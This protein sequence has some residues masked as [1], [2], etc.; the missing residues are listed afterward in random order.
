MAEEQ[1]GLSYT[2]RFIPDTT[3][4]DASITEIAK[5]VEDEVGQAIRKARTTA[6][7][8]DGAP[9]GVT[10]IE[11]AGVV[12]RIISEFRSVKERIT[13]MMQKYG[14]LAGEAMALGHPTG[15][16]LGGVMEK[17][18][19]KLAVTRPEDL[20]DDMRL[21]IAGAMS[22]I[23]QRIEAMQELR[24]DLSK[25]EATKMVMQ[26]RIGELKGIDTKGVFKQYQ[27]MRQLAEVMR[28]ADYY[29][30]TLA[31]VSERAP[32]SVERALM[33]SLTHRIIAAIGKAK[34]EAEGG[35]AD[36][37]HEEVTWRAVYQRLGATEDQIDEWGIP[38]R[39]R[40]ADLFRIVDGKIEIIEF[41]GAKTGKEA[42]RDIRMGYDLF[43]RIKETP[44]MAETVEAMTGLSMED[45]NL[46]TILATAGV[47]GS[48]TAVVE[49]EAAGRPG[50]TATVDDIGGVVKASI[51]G[52]IPDKIA[53]IKQTIEILDGIHKILESLG[54][55][56]TQPAWPGEPIKGP[57]DLSDDAYDESRRSD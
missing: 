50:L 39:I 49:G 57:P 16:T 28:L 7:V 25:E 41:G 53:G 42:S 4:I 32:K 3:A 17:L 21:L 45:I 15:R 5:R 52:L 23:T 44:L 14:I 37:E 51:E 56:P 38:E 35:P 47:F 13:G 6:G 48:V 11:G 33:T 24:P 10:P 9:A 30:D 43:S 19:E 12:D 2:I 18:R 54:A 20:S 55:P 8:G 22:V 34:L 31:G 1:G 40:A 36:W 26:E 27:T 29:K 46:E